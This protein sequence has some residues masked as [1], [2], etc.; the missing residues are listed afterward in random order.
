MSVVTQIDQWLETARK[1]NFKIRYDYFGGTGNSV[2]EFGGNKWLFVDLALSTLDQLEQI[3]Q[4]VKSDP[5]FAMLK[6]NEA[7]P[8][9]AA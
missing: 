1:L 5:L 2:C 4:A 9:K 8:S 6:A 7:G 3:Q